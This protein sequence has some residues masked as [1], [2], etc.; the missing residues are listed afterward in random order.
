MTNLAM[1]PIERAAHHAEA[2]RGDVVSIVSGL[3]TV[4]GREV[5]AMITGRD[6]RQVSRWIAADAKPPMREMQLIRDTY[7][8]VQVLT[9]VDPDEVVRAWF[10]GMNPQLED[11]SPVEALAAGR[12]RDVL[13]AARAFANAG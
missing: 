13:A 2:V 9:D 6:P 4:L 11:E 1:H 3:Q 7:Q 10:L 5:V 12:A 8:I